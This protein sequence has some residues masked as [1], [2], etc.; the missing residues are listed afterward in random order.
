MVPG[1][2]RKKG[3]KF[4][5]EIAALYRHYHIDDS[6]QAMPMS[7]GMEFHKGDILKRNDLSWADEC[8]NQE[9]TKLWEWWNQAVSQAWG[10]QKP[11]LH[12]KRNRVPYPLTVMK[13]DDY[14]Q[15]RREIMDLEEQLKEKNNG[16]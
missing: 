6:A 4:E 9:T 15:L 16:I 11:V 10:S 8:K 13:T 12:I 14:F 5:R 3:K 1:G 7:G 2:Q